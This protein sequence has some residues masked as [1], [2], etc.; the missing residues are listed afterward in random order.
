MT[1]LN[2]KLTLI[3]AVCLFFFASDAVTCQIISGSRLNLGRS[4]SSK[5]REAYLLP[6]FEEFTIEDSDFMAN[7]SV[8][9]R[10]MEQAK[11]GKA[12]KT[13][14]IRKEFHDLTKSEALSYVNAIKA[15]MKTPSTNPD[16]M[17]RGY[18]VF[19]EFFILHTTMY[20]HCHGGSQFLP[21]H[22]AL[23]R[24]F[25]IEL[26]KVDPTVCMPYW[27]QSLEYYNIWDSV[28][29][30][31]YYGTYKASELNK[32][33]MNGLFA[34]TTFTDK[35]YNPRGCIYRN[36]AAPENSNLSSWNMYNQ[37]AN[38]SLAKG[39]QDAY[40]AFAENVELHHGL[41]HAKVSGGMFH[42]HSN[43]DPLFYLH[44]GF[45]DKIWNDFQLHL[46]KRSFSQYNGL[47]SKNLSRALRVNIT[48]ALHP[49]NL[50]V[51]DLL[52]V[53]QLC[54][55]YAAPGEGRNYASQYVKRSHD[56]HVQEVPLDRRGGFVGNPLK[57]PPAALHPPVMPADFI[58]NEFGLTAASN[59]NGTAQDLRSSLAKDRLGSS[60]NRTTLKSS[61]S[62][63]VRG[64]F[65]SAHET[66]EKAVSNARNNSLSPDFGTSVSKQLRS[67]AHIDPNVTF[68][69]ADDSR[70]ESFTDSLFKIINSVSRSTHSSTAL[71]FGSLAIATFAAINS[72]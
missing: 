60:G 37:I 54:Y 62:D 28:V 19:E 69:K 10:L 34:N 16:P 38:D 21:W 51:I 41:L 23:M 8:E 68:Q 24:A 36:M 40:A 13:I 48:D 43:S 20:R 27:D 71:A 50:R 64:A 15:L 65:E 59:L 6:S 46:A 39:S 12:C 67:D 49:W 52:D 61:A 53:K 26:Q 33:V 25:E 47:T 11:F 29:F 32:C 4:S 3:F 35:L 63:S 5:V 55:V 1:P 42:A 2:A 45:V 7:V 17:Y 56:N 44:H 57:K 18:S 58:G 14:C 66:I 31:E 9:S 30:K 72:V 70:E 22:R